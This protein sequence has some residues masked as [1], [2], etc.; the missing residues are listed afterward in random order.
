MIEFTLPSMGADMDEGTLLEWKVKPGDVVK[1]GQVVAIVDTSKAAVDVESWHEGTVDE[2]F[3]NPGERIPVGTPMATLLEPGEAPPAVRHT[4]QPAEPVAVAG[5]APR[6]KISPAARKLAKQHRVDPDSVTGTGP[7]GSVTLA[8][9]ERAIAAVGSPTAG[10][11]GE[12]FPEMRRVIAAAMERSKREIPHYYVSETIPLGKALAWLAAENAARSVT[13][14]LLPAAL[15]LKAVALAL[16]R[17]P[18]LNGFHREGVFRP[19]DAVHLGVA[20]SLRQGGLV[21]PALLD[22][23]AKPLTQ[24]MRELLDLTQRCRAGSLRSSELSEST[25]TV[26]NLGDR[27]AAEVFGIIYP[28]Q[29]ALVGFGR[30]TERPWAEDG[31]LK[32]MPVTTASLSADHRVSDGHRG[33]LFLVELGELLQHPEELN[34]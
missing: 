12:R 26:T 33:S 30:I 24:L 4:R 16:R 18:E 1:K 20:I 31:G 9:V 34:R 27:G 10:A 22:A 15:L 13:D 8:D 25:I 28:P 5:P 32:I 23:D 19:A 3:V 29:V 21:A 17:F 7:A 14:R 2:L 11:P 6:R